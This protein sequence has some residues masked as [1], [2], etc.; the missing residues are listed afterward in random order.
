LIA[1]DANYT[2]ACGLHDLP[3]IKAASGL[4]LSSCAEKADA[5][6]LCALPVN[7]CSFQNL[8]I[9]ASI[10]IGLGTSVAVTQ[11]ESWFVS[12]RL[13][14]T[15]PLKALFDHLGEFYNLLDYY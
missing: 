9:D 12:N 13:K 5:N 11:L 14:L 4:L 8:R 1:V 2:R 7:N 15:T 3:S 6:S 10:N